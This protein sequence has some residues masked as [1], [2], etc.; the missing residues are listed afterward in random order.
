MFDETIAR[1]RISDEKVNRMTTFWWKNHQIDNFLMETSSELR[2]FD[3][4]IVIATTFNEQVMK[5]L[6][7]YEKVVR[8]TTFRWKR[9]QLYE[10]LMKKAS[11]WRLFGPQ[12]FVSRGCLTQLPCLYFSL[13]AIKKP[14]HLEGKPVLA[15]SGGFVVANAEFLIEKYAANI[16]DFWLNSNDFLRML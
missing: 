15:W 10:S 5:W 1:C 4:T 12:V 7:F 9:C 2:I 16:L 13:P 8:I 3:G 11:G 14:G 6:L